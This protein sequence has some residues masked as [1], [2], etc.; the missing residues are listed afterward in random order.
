MRKLKCKKCGAELK[1]N[2]RN[3]VYDLPCADDTSKRRV[4]WE[5]LCS[6]CNMV[7]FVTMNEGK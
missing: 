2:D 4:K 6:G 1:L 5:V 7:H 3:K